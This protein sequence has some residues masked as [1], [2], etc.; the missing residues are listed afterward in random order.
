M[1]WIKRIVLF[2]VE[3]RNGTTITRSPIPISSKLILTRGRVKMTLFFS[4]IKKAA[5]LLFLI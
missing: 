3:A 2:S 1:L 5:A 4:M